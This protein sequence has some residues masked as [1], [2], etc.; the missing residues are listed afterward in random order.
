MTIVTLNFDS[1]AFLKLKPSS[2]LTDSTLNTDAA[3]IAG[4]MQKL[5]IVRTII[6]S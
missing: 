4:V 5:R 1:H 6:S 3:L 2:R